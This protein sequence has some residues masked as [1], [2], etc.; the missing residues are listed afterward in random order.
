MVANAY[1]PCLAHLRRR[2]S[3]VASCEDV[4]EI[5]GY[6]FDLLR[7]K[8]HVFRSHLKLFIV[9]FSDRAARDAVFARGKVFYGPVE[10]QFHAWDMDR[11]AKRTLLPFHVKISIEGLPQ[12]T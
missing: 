12:H 5:I 11:C 3:R 7:Y 9:L 10:L 8:Y 6:N 2:S 1:P 4:A